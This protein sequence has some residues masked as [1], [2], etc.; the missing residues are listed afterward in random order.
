MTSKNGAAVMKRGV[1]VVDDHPLYREGLIRTINHEKDLTVCG[2]ASDASEALKR[3]DALKPDLTVIDISLEGMS[4][5]DLTKSI[6]AKHGKTKILIVSM[7]PES[8]YA[9]RALRAGANGYIMKRESGFV[10]VNAM[11]HVLG[12]QTYISHELNETLIQRLTHSRPGAASSVDLL[13]D[14]ELEVFQ[15]IGRGYGTRQI[16]DELNI[17]MKTVEAH[18]EHIRAKL[19]LDTTFEL[20]Q[21]AIDWMHREKS[22]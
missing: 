8:L 5:I 9:E 16:A 10:L 21:Q 6:R 17:S 1:F 11:R 3:L 4:G 22:L 13:S 14:R 19:N 18:R 15:L 7:H 2:E 20:V 12:G